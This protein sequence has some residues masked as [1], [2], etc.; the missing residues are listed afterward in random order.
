MITQEQ[1]QAVVA[2]AKKREAQG[3]FARARKG[4]SRAGS[5]FVRLVAWDLNPEG[6]NGSW[7]WLSKT[8]GETNVEGFA[9]DAVVG[10]ADPTD[11]LN[12]VDLINGAGAVGASIGGS[13]KERRA[14]NKWVAPKALTPEELSY[15][16]EGGEEKPEAPPRPAIQPY[17]DEQEWWPKVFDVEVAARYARAGLS[18]PDGPRA[19]RWASRVAY[20]IASGMT[21]EDSL[22]KHLKEL[23]AA[24][25]L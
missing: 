16:L 2:Q 10:N 22:A 12:V 6:K 19:F 13:V 20:D 25:G 8:S 24:L 17:P 7:G 23:E 18:Y 14:H 3:Y 9:E 15:L 11:R 4:D 1:L 5:L 21:R